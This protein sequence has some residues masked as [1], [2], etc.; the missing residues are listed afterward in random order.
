MTDTKNELA[1]LEPQG[2]SSGLVN[3]DETQ[4][5]NL[6]DTNKFEHMWRVAQLFSRSDLVPQQ[7]RGKAENC[8]IAA[9]MAVRLQVDPFMFMQNTYVVQGRPGMEAKLAIA[10]I[11]TSGLFTSPLEYEIQGEDPM[12]DGYRVRAYATFRKTGTTIYG[13]W[14]DWKLVKAEGWD[15]KSGSKWKTM[16]AQMFI[17]RAAMFFGRAYCPERLMGMQTIEELDDVGSRYV[18][19]ETPQRGTIGL[20]QALTGTPDH[21][22]DPPAE[23]APASAEDSGDAATDDPLLSVAK[24]DRFEALVDTVGT[25]RGC[26]TMDDAQAAA[27]ELLASLKCDRGSCR[28]DKKWAQI[29]A[30]ATK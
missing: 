10:L 6:L 25:I 2:K 16:P 24:D 18:E 9:Q 14:I 8:F 20:K 27:D 19:N 15:S 12:K 22:P 30:A 5:G 1:A 4:F 28:I 29:V 21:D 17:Y 23:E 3:I 26:D 7:Y 13:P 11:N